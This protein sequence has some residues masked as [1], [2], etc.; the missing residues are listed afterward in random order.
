MHSP[1]PFLLLAVLVAGC[2]GIAGDRGPAAPMTAVPVPTYAL[3]PPGPSNSTGALALAVPA[4]W[5]LPVYTSRESGE[6]CS[7]LVVETN[8]TVLSTDVRAGA[9]RF[10]VVDGDGNRYPVSIENVRDHDVPPL[11]IESGFASALLRVMGAASPGRLPV[12]VH[13]RLVSFVRADA[14][15]PYVLEYLVGTPAPDGTPGTAWHTLASTAIPAPEDGLRARLRAP[16]EHA[17]AYGA[18]VASVDRAR[19]VPLPPD[20]EPAARTLLTEWNIT[21]LA[22]EGPYPAGVARS[23]VLDVRLSTPGSDLIDLSTSLA[24]PASR[25]RFVLVDGPGFFEYRP[26]TDVEVEET[27]STGAAGGS[28]RLNATFLVL[29]VPG[30]RYSLELRGDDTGEGSAT[31]LANATVPAPS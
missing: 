5:G 30:M 17:R 12:T 1:V 24:G 15:P 22:Q 7:L 6:G 28:V 25:G 11:A 31:L 14:R 23:L 27:A 21:G 26:I 8:F 9:Q 20:Q 16:T 3:A 18:V 2:T 10:A 13:G 4:A 19:L 29:D